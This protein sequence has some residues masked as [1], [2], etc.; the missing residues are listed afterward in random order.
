MWHWL[1]SALCNRYSWCLSARKFFF[2]QLIGLVFALHVLIVLGYMLIACV[3]AKKHRYDVSL[4]RSGLTYVLMPLQKTV[5]QSRVT[6]SG[7]V[8]KKSNVIDLST[9]QARKKNKKKNLEKKLPAKT[10]TSALSKQK[11]PVVP[12][13]KQPSVVV[14][15]QVKP[16]KKIKKEK[17][18]VQTVQ[19]S[20]DIQ[21]V[22]SADLEKQNVPVLQPEP[23]IPPAIEEKS[24]GVQ[25]KSDDQNFDE[26]NVV[27]IGYQDLDRSVVGSKI[28]H[29]IQQSWAAPVGMSP[30]TSCEIQLKIS[31][32]GH[33]YESKIIKSSGVFVYDS[34]AKKTLQMIE[35]PQEVW[36]KTITIVLGA[37]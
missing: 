17:T 13:K 8:H 2:L 5:Q 9:Y 34:T 21:N 35:Y 27:F 25:Q 15:D 20:L 19:M 18:T 28:Q 3:F 12:A 30:G 24:V 26:N 23:V 29:T 36:N 7:N 1:P 14:T 6:V 16:S 37:T 22:L 31:E 32:Q 33:A 10:L 4:A 11:N